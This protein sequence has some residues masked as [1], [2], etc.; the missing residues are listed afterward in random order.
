MS[1]KI[2]DSFVL[3]AQSKTIEN[4]KQSHKPANHMLIKTHVAA[5]QPITFSLNTRYMTNYFM[6]LNWP[7]LPIIGR[8]SLNN[9]LF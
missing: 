9:S 8:I 4:Q 5:N 2:E 6:Q 3:T 7:N 1:S